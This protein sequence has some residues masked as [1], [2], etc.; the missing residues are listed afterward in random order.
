MYLETKELFVEPLKAA[1]AKPFTLPHLVSWLE[2]KN[3]SETYCYTDGGRCLVAT[4]YKEFEPRFCACDPDV[5]Y[6][7]EQN[8]FGL[9]RGFDCIACSA[10]HTFGAALS[11]A[12]AA[13]ERL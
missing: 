12:Q 8:E 10:P 4:Y 2:T 1:R 11:R 7:S 13:L 9:P 6:D 3:P 5:W